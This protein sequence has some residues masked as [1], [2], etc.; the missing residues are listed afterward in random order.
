M[1]AIL[2]RQEWELQCPHLKTK[3]QWK[4][5]NFKLKPEAQPI[6]LIYQQS[7]PVYLYDAQMVQPLTPQELQLKEQQRRHQESLKTCSKC[8]QIQKSTTDLFKALCS[9]CLNEKLYLLLN[10]SAES[11]IFHQTP[12]DLVNLHQK[13]NKIGDCCKGIRSENEVCLKLTLEN[14]ETLAEQL[15]IKEYSR[16]HQTYEALKTKRDSLPP[17]LERPTL[18]KEI[19]QEMNRVAYREGYMF[20][21]RVHQVLKEIQEV[22][23]TQENMKCV[24]LIN[25]Q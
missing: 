20:Y 16:L 24:I 15:E 6:A 18:Q 7:K 8:H 23:K 3:N 12:L 25:K 19:Q 22:I 5:L 21:H 13:F 11:T 14:M 2:D 10:C 1:V 17:S 4:K 9:S